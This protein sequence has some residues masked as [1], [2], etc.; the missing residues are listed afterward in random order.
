MQIMSVMFHAILVIIPSW[1]FLAMGSTP[2]AAGSLHRMRLA[3]VA[4]GWVALVAHAG[5][6][7]AVAG[8]GRQGMPKLKGPQAAWQAMAAKQ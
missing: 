8:G 6:A 3:A 5:M 1:Y 4:V 7:V 2:T